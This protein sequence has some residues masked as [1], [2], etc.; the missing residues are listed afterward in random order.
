M[1]NLIINWR[2][3]CWFFQVVR[4]DDWRGY[5]QM[6]QP[7]VRWS[8]SQ[9]HARGGPARRGW[10]WPVAIYEGRGY[11]GMLLLAVLLLVLW[12]A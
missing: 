7:V 8:R 6:G 4:P 2:F 11:F 3:W 12:L 9:Y 5:R 10:W 1:S